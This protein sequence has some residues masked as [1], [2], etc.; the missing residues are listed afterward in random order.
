[1]LHKRVQRATP[2]QKDHLVVE[3]NFPL[4]A[5]K[6]VTQSFGQ[7]ELAPTGLAAPALSVVPATQRPD[8]PNDKA[9]RGEEADAPG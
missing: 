3:I 8:Q 9:P 6:N 4:R 5:H 1:V 7:Q 2:G